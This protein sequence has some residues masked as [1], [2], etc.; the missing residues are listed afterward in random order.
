MRLV[1][2]SMAIAILVGG[3]ASVAEMDYKG[4]G[5]LEPQQDGFFKF[6]TFGSADYPENDPEIEKVRLAELGRQLK[7]NGLCKDG[8]S[9]DRRQAVLRR[10][11]VL[12]DLHTIFYYGRCK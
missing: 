12:G 4:A 1:F 3:C 7:I 10:K 2:L 8:H 5:T 9:V 11:A 6:T